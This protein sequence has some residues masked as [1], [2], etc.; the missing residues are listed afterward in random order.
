[1]TR[2]RPPRDAE[3]LVAL[4]AGQLLSGDYA[5]SDPTLTIDG[6]VTVAEKLVDEVYSRDYADER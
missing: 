1:M 5:S 6:V 3:I 2:L 4:V